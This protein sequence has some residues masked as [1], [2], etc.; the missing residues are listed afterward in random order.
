MANLL[1][2]HLLP[3]LAGLAARLRTGGDFVYSGA[4]TVER[5][6]LMARFRAFGLA[7]LG[8]KIDGEWSAWRLR[9]EPGA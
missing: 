3:E 8:E 6:E 4:L 5:R 1:S 7:P 9:A 2:A